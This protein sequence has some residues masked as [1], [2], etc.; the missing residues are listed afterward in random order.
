MQATFTPTPTHPHS[1]KTRQMCDPRIVA[2]KKCG[3]S[4]YDYSEDDYI[5]E[6]KYT[7]IVN[8]V[9]CK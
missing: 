3:Q 7:N 6:Y 4:R 2:E 1:S 5:I 8:T 9:P